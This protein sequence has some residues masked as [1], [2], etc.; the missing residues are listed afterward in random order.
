MSVPPGPYSDTSSSN[1]LTNQTKS[2]NLLGLVWDSSKSARSHSNYMFAAKTQCCHRQRNSAVCQMPGQG[3]V[4][5]GGMGFYR[6][7]VCGT[8]VGMV[9]GNHGWEIWLERLYNLRRDKRDSHERPHK[10]VLLLSI[11]D[12]LDR[13]VI[14]SNEVPLSEELVTTFKRYFAVVRK[15]DDRPTI[16][17]LFF[18][19]CGDKLVPA[20]GETAIYREGATAGAPRVAELRRRVA[21]GRFDDG[22]WQLMREPMARRCL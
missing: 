22:L 3:G 2:S 14:T 1:D 21:H 10:P 15:H 5:A 17:N 20:P 7:G 11:I 12:L 19:L 4:V 6:L 13:R 8:I 18:H 16:Q 9:V